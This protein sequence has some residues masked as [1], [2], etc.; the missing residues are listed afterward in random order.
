M[1]KAIEK[2]EK[3]SL[4]GYDM[5]L[6][7]SRGSALIIFDKESSKKGLCVDVMGTLPNIYISS[8]ILSNDEKKQLV[9][10]LKHGR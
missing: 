4:G 1:A 9:N 6:D 5:W 10:Y 3:I 8:S 2:R 7:R